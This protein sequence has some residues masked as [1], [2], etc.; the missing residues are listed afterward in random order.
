MKLSTDGTFRAEVKHLWSSK[1]FSS[2]VIA[3][4]KCIFR[5]VL[6]L[7]LFIEIENCLY[8]SYRCLKDLRTLH[9]MA[10]MLQVALSV[11]LRSVNKGCWIHGSRPVGSEANANC[12]YLNVC[13]SFHV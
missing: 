1:L 10:L 13:L 7:L 12:L 11:L 6:S 5:V 2:Y 8:E 3:T 9:H 4:K